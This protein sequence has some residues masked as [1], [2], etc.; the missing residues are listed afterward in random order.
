LGP[1][2]PNPDLAT[3]VRFGSVR[4]ADFFGQTRFDI[5]VKSASGWGFAVEGAAGFGIWLPIDFGTGFDYRLYRSI[6]DLEVGVGGVVSAGCG[7]PLPLSCGGDFTF[8]GNLIVDHESGRLSVRSENFVWFFPGFDF[9]SNTELEFRATDRLRAVGGFE[10]WE[11]G[12]WSAYVGA[13]FDVTE[14]LE[15]WGALIIDTG[16]FGFIRVGAELDL[17]MIDPY[18]AFYWRPGAWQIEAGADLEKPLGT[19]P[20]SLVGDINV[21]YSMPCCGLGFEAGFGIRYTIGDNDEY[22]ARDYDGS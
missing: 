5:D 6:G 17:G 2:G 10:F 18:V 8:N 14:Q 20:Y 7:G 11:I 21:R 12:N 13:E 9:Y 22:R 19:G 15:I 1:G 4:G 3:A 16:E